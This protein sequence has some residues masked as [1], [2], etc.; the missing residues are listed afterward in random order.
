[1]YH[2][3][4]RPA[5]AAVP[6]AASSPAELAELA[7]L[8]PAEPTAEPGPAE[9]TK[10]VLVHGTL[11]R[12]AGMLR[13][14][15]CLRDFEQTRYDRRGYGRS[16]SAGPA[17]SF[18]QQLADLAA[19]IGNQRSIIFGHSY[20]GV[21]ALALAA[22]HHP[23]IAAVVSFEAPR[24]W[25]P[26]WTP[27]PTNDLLEKAAAANAA[28]Q[29]CR[30]MMGDQTWEAL[31][32]ATRTQRRQE[33]PTMIA[34]LQHQSVRQY[35]ATKIAVPVVIGVGELSGPRT[36][37]AAKLTANEAAAGELCCVAGAGHGAPTSHPD[38][39]AGLVRRAHALLL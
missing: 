16:F 25:E 17:Q 10:V 23:A 15:R 4:R 14:A 37:R 3:A 24:A 2:H 12:G 33:G 19:I 9:P 11:D 8:S 18:T 34:E 35:D 7:E 21:L 27:P 30:S 32:L 22:Q 39:V 31:P 29:F 1:M 5:V 6:A 13:V 20:G 36:Q 28:E 26:W 38:A